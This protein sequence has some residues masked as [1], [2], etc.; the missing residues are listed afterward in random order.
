MKILYSSHE[1]FTK[2]R[3]NMFINIGLEIEIWKSNAKTKF[4]KTKQLCIFQLTLLEAEVVSIYVAMT[5][6]IPKRNFDKVWI[7]GEI[8]VRFTFTSLCNAGE[9]L[10][11]HKLNLC[12][13]KRNNTK[14][15]ISIS[16]IYI[17]TPDNMKWFS[18]FYGNIPN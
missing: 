5:L 13:K 6:D 17:S 12:W 9:K 2:R 8:I 10:S 15:H 3:S 14:R 1:C 7:A 16:C 4:C 11:N 18:T